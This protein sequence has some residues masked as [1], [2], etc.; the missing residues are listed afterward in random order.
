MTDRNS[1]HNNLRAI[2]TVYAG[3]RFRSR[4]EADYAATFDSIGLP[5]Q[6]EPEGYQLS[7]GTWYSPDFY[8]PSARAWCEVKGDHDERIS[9][10]EQ[11]AADL[12]EAAGGH[13]IHD[14]RQ[15]PEYDS[16]DAPLIILARAPIRETDPL[17]RGIFPP[18]R[19]RIHGVRGPGKGHSVGIAR[20]PNCNQ[21]T[22]I[23]LWSRLC[24]ACG[25]VHDDALDAW[26]RSV[27]DHYLTKFVHLQRP[28][29]KPPTLRVINKFTPINLSD[30]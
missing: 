27:L 18:F 15:Q 16:I 17:L 4:L 6:Y 10:V 24:R 2:E 30:S 5:W 13:D 9:K 14:G 26:Q 25:Y 8:L 21:T 29:G 19:P 12:W 11:F 20:C 28:A 7:D 1:S 3:A 23:A 22:I